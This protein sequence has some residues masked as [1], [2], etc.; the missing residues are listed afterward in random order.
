MIRFENAGKAFKSRRV[1]NELI[2]PLRNFTATIADGESTG[3]LVPE[4][5]GKTTLM[6][7]VAGNESLTEGDIQRS[8]HISWPVSNRSMFNAKMTGRQN[9]RFLTDCYGRNFKATYDFLMDFSELGR[10]IDLPIRQYSG[11]QR[12][13]LALTSIFALNFDFILVDDVFEAGDQAFRRKIMQ[14]VQANKSSFTFLIATG[15]TKLVERYCERAGILHGGT[16]VFYE[17]IEEAKRNFAD[18]TGKPVI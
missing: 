11:E 14:Y 5:G 12:Y 7:V 16:V 9:L 1:K 13:R 10:H 18:I 15:N 6:D 3:I 17:S 8:G 2:W 4:G